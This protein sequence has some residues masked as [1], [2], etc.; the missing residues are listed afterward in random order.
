MLLQKFLFF[1]LFTLTYLSAETVLIT[2]ANRGLGLEFAKQY[3]AKGYDVIGTAR[4]SDEADELRALNVRVE[5][6]DVANEASI[7]SL[8]KKLKG[9]PIDILI[10]NAGIMRGRNDDLEMIPKEDMQQSFAVNA[11]GPLLVTQ[12]L[13]PNLRSGKNQRIVNITS[14]LGSIQNNTGGGMYPYRASKA[15]L[16]QISKT[17]SVELKNDGI[18][19]V[20]L[21][22][23][24][25][26]T[27]MG[28]MWATYSPE[29]AVKAMINTIDRLNM[30]SN[31]RF[32][33]LNGQELP[34]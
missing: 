5:R 32:L 23:G 19:T 24:W 9:V 26:R 4:D 33:D 3:Q 12:A 30:Q 18:I 21:H 29:Q 17:M 22:P 13:L 31:G 16:N 27:D 34:W 20:A 8:G 1:L 11:T 14:Q 2:G 7:Q 25:V 6:L 10:N 28:G 15:A